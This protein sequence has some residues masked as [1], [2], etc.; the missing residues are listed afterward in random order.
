MHVAGKSCW[1]QP[2]EGHQRRV[3]VTDLQVADR[4][5]PSTTRAWPVSLS[6][7]AP[8]TI[9]AQRAALFCA[10]AIYRAALAR[11][12]Y[13]VEHGN[14]LRGRLQSRW[15]TSRACGVADVQNHV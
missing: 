7:R 14:H 4:S 1:L 2:L 15:I 11:F 3:K 6:S 9:R 5:L 12:V 8:V 10:L 13:R